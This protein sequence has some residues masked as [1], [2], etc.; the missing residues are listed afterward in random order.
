MGAQEVAGALEGRV[1][2]GHD[3]S[4]ESAEVRGEG[5]ND[6]NWSPTGLIAFDRVPAGDLNL[7]VVPASGGTR[8]LVRANGLDPQWNPASDH[9]VFVDATD[10]SLRTIDLR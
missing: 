2:T 10:I 7:Y 6:A 8:R 1:L 5:G 3:E 9:L 4:I